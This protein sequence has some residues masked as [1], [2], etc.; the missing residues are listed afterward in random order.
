MFDQLLGASRRAVKG[1]MSQSDDDYENRGGQKE[2]ER[3]QNDHGY[4]TMASCLLVI[5]FILQNLS[6]VLGFVSGRTNRILSSRCPTSARSVLLR[7]ARSS[8]IS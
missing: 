6:C 1:T 7:D 8:S 5:P 2:Q 4:S 3:S